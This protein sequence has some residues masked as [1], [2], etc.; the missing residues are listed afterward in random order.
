M[1]LSRR[2]TAVE[3]FMDQTGLPVHAITN[4]SDVFTHLKATPVDGKTYVTPKIHESYLAYM[5]KYG[6]TTADSVQQR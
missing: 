1:E 5:K 2:K 6:V 3:E 4:I